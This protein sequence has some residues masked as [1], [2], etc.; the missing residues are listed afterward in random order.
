MEPLWQRWLRIARHTL[1]TRLAFTPMLTLIDCTGATSENDGRK[2]RYGRVGLGQKAA[3]DRPSGADRRRL[4]RCATS[5]LASY[6]L[7]LMHSILPESC[8]F[9][10]PDSRILVMDLDIV[11]VCRHHHF[12]IDIADVVTSPL[13]G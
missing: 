10:L 1:G 7:T 5:I 2:G 11:L 13:L 12:S 8:L 9:R 4:G 3:Q 6:L